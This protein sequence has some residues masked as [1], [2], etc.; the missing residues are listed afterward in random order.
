MGGLL[1]PCQL[2]LLGDHL[3]NND[4]LSFAHARRKGNMKEKTSNGFFLFYANLWNSFLVLLVKDLKSEILGYWEVLF[5]PCLFINMSC[6]NVEIILW[7][8][9]IL[10]RVRPTQWMMMTSSYKW[11]KQRLA[12]L[13]CR[14]FW[15]NKT[16][17]KKNW[18]QTSHRIALK[19]A[20]G[21][22]MLISNQFGS[23]QRKFKCLK[24]T[25]SSEKTMHF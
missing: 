5:M 24:H 2:E 17:K 20:R 22:F 7:L 16:F 18:V 15:V 12:N 3:L 23:N 4:V 9:Y 11:K 13:L 14:M 25:D 6:S 21:F 8:T 1:C 10:F 19:L